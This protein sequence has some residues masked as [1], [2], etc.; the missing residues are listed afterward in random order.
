MEEKSWRINLGSLIFERQGSK[1]DRELLKKLY[2]EI[3]L[4]DMSF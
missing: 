2:K 4:K 1:T 3:F